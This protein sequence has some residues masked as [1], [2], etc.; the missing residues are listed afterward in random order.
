MC[1]STRAYRPS[2]HRRSVVAAAAK[3]RFAAAPRFERAYPSTRRRPADEAARGG[4][5]GCHATRVAFGTSSVRTPAEEE[6]RAPRGEMSRSRGARRRRRRA[7]RDTR[8]TPPRGSSAEARETPGPTRRPEG[9]KTR[10]RWDPDVARSNPAAASS[11]FFRARRGASGDAGRGRRGTRGGGVE[12][13]GPVES[14]ALVPSRSGETET[15]TGGRLGAG[16]SERG[17]GG[18]GNNDAGRAKARRPGVEGVVVSGA[19]SVDRGT[20][21]PG[22][23]SRVRRRARRSRRSTRSI[24]APRWI[25]RDGSTAG[26]GCSRPRPRPPRRRRDRRRA[27]VESAGRAAENQTPSPPTIVPSPPVNAAR[28]AA[29]RARSARRMVAATRAAALDRERPREGT[30]FEPRPRRRGV[31]AGLPPRRGVAARAA[32]GDRE[33][34]SRRSARPPPSPSPVVA[35]RFVS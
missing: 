3:T 18:V 1:A 24:E 32:D 4:R 26:S 27:G 29:V 17:G 35:R 5:C 14:D 13:L 34:P 20:T 7:T 11:I 19:A 25:D 33:D 9:R 21:E 16:R 8:R 22:A 28:D 12:R 31:F 6:A 15:K 23:S 2:A 30:G 10:S